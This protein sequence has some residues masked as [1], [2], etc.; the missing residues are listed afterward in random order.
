MVILITYK[1][2]A[3]RGKAKAKILRKTMT[4]AIALAA[5]FWYVSII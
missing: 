5:Y 4:A 2:G 1:L 3:I